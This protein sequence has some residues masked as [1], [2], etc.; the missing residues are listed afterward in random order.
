MGLDVLV[1]PQQA[2]LGVRI[3]VLDLRDRIAWLPNHYGGACDMM[4]SHALYL[5]CTWVAFFRGGRLVDLG[6][7][8]NLC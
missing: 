6:S 8:C 3:I 2:F 7:S 5:Y 1:T 4:D